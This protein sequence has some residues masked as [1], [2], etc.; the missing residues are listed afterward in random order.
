M[1]K[2]FAVANR[3]IA[4][5]MNWGPWYETSVCISICLI[6]IAECAQDPVLL[7]GNRHDMTFSYSYDVNSAVESS[8]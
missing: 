2:L 6:L 7:S 3:A 1:L 5:E 8:D 4:R